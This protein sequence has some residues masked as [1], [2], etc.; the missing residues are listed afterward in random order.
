MG[1]FTRTRDIISA[2]IN[3]LLDEAEDP[4]KLANLMVRE[5]EDTLIEL[6]A[7][8]AGAMAA[9]RRVDRERGD[10]KA[11]AADWSE[12]AQ[13]AVDK[14]RDDLAREALL[15]RRRQQERVESIEKELAQLESV[16][17]QYQEDIKQLE[18]KLG[19]AREKQR[20]LVHRHIHAVHKRR[21]QMEIRRMDESDVFA[22]IHRVQQRLE[23]LEADA[24]LE[25]PPRGMSLREEIDALDD[26]NEIENELR[27]LKAGSDRGS[28]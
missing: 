25:E 3:A 7:S 16:L 15:E 5:M 2:N 19:V 23:R 17:N 27:A 12:R 10:A 24:G 26:H 20:V 11:L 9:R 28:L 13:R 4:E 6:K 1:I 18:E 14:G 8:C 22:R 21:A